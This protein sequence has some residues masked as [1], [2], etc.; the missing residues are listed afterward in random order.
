[1]PRD[2]AR[3][4]TGERPPR[5]TRISGD[6]TREKILTAAEALF[7][8]QSFDSVSL[9]DITLDAGV[10]LA[11]ASYHFGSKEALFEAVVA[12]RADILCAM[13]QARL[14]ALV[15]P[16]TRDLLDAF[17]APLFEKARSGEPG[18]GDYLRVL[19][20]L[21]EQDRWLGLFARHFDPTARLFIAALEKALPGARREDVSRTF[22]LVL[23]GMLKTVSRHARLDNL[24]EGTA[25][26][27]DLDRAYPT[28]LQFSVAGMESFATP[29]RRRR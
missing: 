28:L 19:A 29:N 7:A 17:L 21:G 27:R 6:Q 16:T 9:R 1:M 4:A 24:T 8:G 3:P 25:R 12:R 26:A 22:L 11:L 5:P 2:N 10:T 15:D 23:E 13:R 14:A 18:W 20:R